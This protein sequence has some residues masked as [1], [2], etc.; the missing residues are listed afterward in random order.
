MR[1]KPDTSPLRGI[2][3]QM[4]S[5]AHYLFCTC[6]SAASLV[7]A[8][9]QPESPREMALVFEIDLAQGRCAGV[10]AGA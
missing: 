1:Q 2:L 6:L 3:T 9:T 7:I 4:T 5:K 10:H 8:R